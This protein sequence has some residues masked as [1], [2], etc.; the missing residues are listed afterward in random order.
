[1]TSALSSIADKLKTT[2]NMTHTDIDAEEQSY[3]RDVDACKQWW[4]DSR[5]RYT[6][7]PY[8]AEQIVQKRGTLKIEYPSNAMAKKLW[9]MMESRFAVCLNLSHKSTV[10]RADD[11]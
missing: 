5:W 8:T 4:T 11:C 10:Q 7:R 6:R 3:L 1:M 9:Q 2:L